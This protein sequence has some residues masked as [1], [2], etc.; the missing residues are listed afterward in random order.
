MMPGLPK[1]NGFVICYMDKYDED[2]MY[3]DE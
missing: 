1:L 3:G 2:A